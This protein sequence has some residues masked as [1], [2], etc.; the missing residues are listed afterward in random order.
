MGLAYDDG[1]AIPFDSPH[2]PPLPAHYRG[3]EMQLVFFE[4]DP[5][6][7]ARVLPEPLQPDPEGLCVAI[8]L[9]VPMDFQVSPAFV[10]NL[11]QINE[12]GHPSTTTRAEKRSGA[13]Q[14]ASP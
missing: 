13:A 10:A 3:V 2:Y 11:R 12:S 4:T 8:G 9:R 6:A 5:G 7:V 14:T 1:W